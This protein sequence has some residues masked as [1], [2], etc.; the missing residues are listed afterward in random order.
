[1][2]LALTLGVATMGSVANAQRALKSSSARSTSRA[3]VAR[4]EYGSAQSLGNGQ[5]RAYVVR[6]DGTGA[7]IEVGVA[8]SEAAMENLPAAMHHAGADAAGAHVM[9]TELIL[10]LPA[11]HGTQFKFVQVGWNPAGHEPPGVYDLPHFDFHFYNISKDERDKIVPTN[12]EYVTSARNA[13]EGQYARE[14]FVNPAVALKAPAEA[15]AVPQMGVHWLDARSPE[16]QRM[17]GNPDGYK[18]FTATYIQGAW[19]GKFI[20]EEPM[21]TRA[22]IMARKSATDSAGR[23]QIIPLSSAVKASPAG[24]Y[25]AAYRIQYDA[26]SKEY[27]VALTKLAYKE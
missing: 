24:Y 17:V 7:P 23:D 19:N 9:S 15:L 3:D 13:P 25:P 8:F 20:F 5:V 10:Q 1:M 2:L 12:P 14:F 11:N 27:R 16:L 21:I 26:A 4:R 6:K 18:P 22:H